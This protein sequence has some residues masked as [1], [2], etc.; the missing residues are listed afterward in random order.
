MALFWGVV[1]VVAWLSLS[2]WPIIGGVDDIQL[3]IGATG[4]PGTLTVESCIAD[5]TGRR[6]EYKCTGVFVPDD[7]SKPV[8][9]VRPPEPRVAGTTVPVQLADDGVTT[10][11]SGPDGVRIALTAPAM[12][13]VVFFGVLGVALIALTVQGGSGPVVVRRSRVTLVRIL[14][15]V[16]LAVA[17]LGV[18]TVVVGFVSLAN[19]PGVI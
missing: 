8:I 13:V 11:L 1:G 4:T 3:A 12:G 15:V 2:L 9:S 6:R 16:A 10:R 7:P 14:A 5:D 18:V 19:S 17:V